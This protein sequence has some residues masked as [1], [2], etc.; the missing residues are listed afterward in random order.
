MYYLYYAG[1]AA[2]RQTEQIGLA[3]SPDGLT[4]QRW[5]EDGLLIPR[6]PNVAWKALR[7]CN[8]FVLRHEGTWLMYYQG[9]G[10]SAAGDVSHVIARARS[11][12]G[13]RWECDPE[14]CLSFDD[15]RAAVP[16]FSD[17]HHGGVIEPA[18]LADGDSLTMYFICYKQT[19]REGTWL[20]SARSRD[21]ARWR[22]DAGTV[23]SGRAFGRY[24]LHYPQAVDRRTLWLSLISLDNNASAVVRLDRNAEG[25][26]TPRQLLPASDGGELEVGPQATITL[27]GEGKPPRGLGRINQWANRLLHGGRN[28]WG[29]SHPHVIAV[30]GEER[31]YYHAYHRNA[32]GEAWMDI[33]SCTTTGADHRVALAPPA[34]ARAWDAFFVADP[35]VAIVEG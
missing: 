35:F 18:L 4:F 13:R 8:P 7:T 5:H 26:W 34:D 6:D 12:D 17:Q 27:G 28:Y 31:L 1:M 15:V 16:E 2:D 3:T 23:M 24:R 33:G 19:Y 11:V 10:R 20:L 14:P 32:A 22:V 29:Y 9:V 30:R 21:G 25:Q